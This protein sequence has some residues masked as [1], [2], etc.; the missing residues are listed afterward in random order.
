[1]TSYRFIV[2]RIAIWTVSTG[3]GKNELYGTIMRPPAFYPMTTARWPAGSCVSY[4]KHNI[5]VGSGIGATYLLT[6][7][8]HQQE[9][10]SADV[11]HGGSITRRR[12]EWQWPAVGP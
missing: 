9:W 8:W 5:Y 7:S 11:T 10:R 1:M 12:D 3:R 6:C 4:P 2:I